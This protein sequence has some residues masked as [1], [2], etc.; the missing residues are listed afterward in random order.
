MGAFLSSVVVA[1]SLI[2]GLAS[3]SYLDPA[4]DALTNDSLKTVL[5][6]LGLEPKALSKGYLVALKPKGAWV[7]NMQLVLSPSGTK[8][9]FNANL[10]QVPDV[11]AVT[12][13]QWR[14]LLERNAT[15]EPTFFYF[16]PEAKKLYLHRVLDN[17]GL[18]PAILRQ[19]IDTFSNSVV[20]T[21][22]DWKFTK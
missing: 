4:P 8:L 3:R 7:V 11:T 15:I 2:S 18:T 12:A 6:G 20:D 9:G 10:G 13:D 19:E 22:A 17:R 14:T 5:D 16:D 21:E 1:A